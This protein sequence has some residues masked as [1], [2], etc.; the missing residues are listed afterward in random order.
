MNAGDAVAA[1]LDG[2]PDALYVSSLGTATSALRDASSD[3][4]HLY[5]GGAMGCGLPVALGVAGRRPERQVVAIVGDGDLLMGAGSLLSLA[6]LRPANLLVVVLEDGRYSITGGQE[7]VAR[8]MLLASAG[9]L[10]GLAISEAATPTELTDAV[11]AAVCPALVAAL[12]SER[13]TPIAS[14]FVDP[15]AVRARFAEYAAGG[16][17]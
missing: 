4:P 17:D 5:L 10:D 2:A 11:R 15:P 1:V 14:P 16:V 12:V 7:L 6:G 8:P 3:G 9:G 13:L